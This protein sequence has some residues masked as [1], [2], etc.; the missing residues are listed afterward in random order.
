MGPLSSHTIGGD[1][2]TRTAITRGSDGNE[3]ELYLRVLLSRH[4]C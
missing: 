2:T 4:I 3:I 1:D